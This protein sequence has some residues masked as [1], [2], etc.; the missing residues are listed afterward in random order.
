MAHGSMYRVNTPHRTLVSNIYGRLARRQRSAKYPRILSSEL[1]GPL[2]GFPGG[3]LGLLGEEE[4]Q[5]QP[6]SCFLS[7]F[8]LLLGSDIVPMFI[9]QTCAIHGNSKA[10]LTME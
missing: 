4:A 10:R 7:T 6:Y 9:V 8:N 1:G 3:E 5:R 2:E